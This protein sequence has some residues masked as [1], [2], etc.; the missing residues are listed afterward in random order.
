MVIAVMHWE[1]LMDMY[2][3]FLSVQYS[4]ETVILLLQPT[5]VEIQIRMV[6]L[7]EH[8]AVSSLP[9]RERERKP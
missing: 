8:L 9:I 3:Q 6:V 4:E 7:R 5:S 1:Q 2:M